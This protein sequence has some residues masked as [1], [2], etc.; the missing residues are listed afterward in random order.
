MFAPI[1]KAE[2]K[3]CTMT[4]GDHLPTPNVLCLLHALAR[5]LDFLDWSSARWMHERTTSWMALFAMSSRHTRIC[6]LIL[7]FLGFSELF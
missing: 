5:S 6:L 7:L 1:T 3:K 4:T 2:M